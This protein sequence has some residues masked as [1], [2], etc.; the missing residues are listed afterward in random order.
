MKAAGWRLSNLEVDAMGRKLLLYI[1][2][3]LVC[4]N[5]TAQVSNNLDSLLA[6]EK[7]CPPGPEKIKLLRDIGFV[8]SRKDSEKALDYLKQAITLGEQI[9]ESKYT[10]P[11]KC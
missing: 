1:V 4:P 2:F 11:W 8:Y 7:V 10:N 6:A 5:L 3:L 9:N